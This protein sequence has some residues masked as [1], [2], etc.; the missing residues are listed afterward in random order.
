[1]PGIGEHGLADRLDRKTATIINIVVSW[2][3]MDIAVRSDKD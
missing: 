3:S 2:W 1:M